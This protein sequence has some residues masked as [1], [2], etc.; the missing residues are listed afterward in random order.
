MRGGRTL[1]DY[2]RLPPACRVEINIT[3]ASL[4]EQTAITRTEARLLDGSQV[5]SLQL[6]GIVNQN[7]A[8][9]EAYS[10]HSHHIVEVYFIRV[11]IE[12][13]EMERLWKSVAHMLHKLIP[14]PCV[15]LM[16]SDDL[17]RY[18][19]SLGWK[20]R[21]QTNEDQR[22]VTEE[23]FSEDITFPADPDFEEYLS[24]ENAEK[25]HLQ[26]FYKYYFRVLKNHRM[27]SLS[28]GFVLRDTV[29]TEALWTALHEIERYEKDIRGLSRQIRTDSQMK[30]R[31]Q[32][33][34]E[35]YLLREKVKKLKSLFLTDGA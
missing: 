28:G 33:N 8:N 31:V 23:I 29:E 18:H 10:D 9:I 1:M 27:S 3:K 35:I 17:S 25:R 6:A 30:E 34:K 16:G 19:I 22:V 11:V 5:K 24:F 4:K 7:T 2:F 20:I 12:E 13:Q 21:H 26:Q 14:H 32:L 15:V